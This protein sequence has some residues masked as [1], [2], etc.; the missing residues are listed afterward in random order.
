LDREEELRH[1][2]IEALAKEMRAANQSERRTYSGARAQAQCG[3]CMLDRD[4]R[5]SRICSEDAADAS[6]AR[7]WG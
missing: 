3:L 6:R 7:S 4:V 5:L 2:L 1:C